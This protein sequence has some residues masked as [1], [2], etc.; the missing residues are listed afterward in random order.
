MRAHVTVGMVQGNIQNLYKIIYVTHHTNTKSDILVLATL[1]VV[2]S[3]MM[4]AMAQ[5]KM[6]VMLFS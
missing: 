3:M 1:I 4:M 2:M 6:M 5:N